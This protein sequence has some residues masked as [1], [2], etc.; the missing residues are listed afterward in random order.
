LHFGGERIVFRP[1][2]LQFAV[3]KVRLL[4]R[5]VD[6]DERGPNRVETLPRRP[7]RPGRAEARKSDEDCDDSE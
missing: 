4:E 7:L 6:L 1:Q 3:R 2:T 5:R